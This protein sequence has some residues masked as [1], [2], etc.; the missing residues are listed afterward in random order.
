MPTIFFFNLDS[1][2]SNRGFSFRSINFRSCLPRQEIP[3]EGEQIQQ[4]DPTITITTADI[5][6]S[7]VRHRYL[8]YHHI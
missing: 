1:I 8:E 4:R 2:F 6:S 7:A 5:K 3:H